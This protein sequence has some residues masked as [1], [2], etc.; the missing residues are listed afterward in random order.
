MNKPTAP[1]N[2]HLTREGQEFLAENDPDILEDTVAVGASRPRRHASPDDV[3]AAIASFQAGDSSL[4]GDLYYN[5]APVFN[6]LVKNVEPG[7]REDAMSLVDEGFTHALTATN[8]ETA[9]NPAGYF[10][11]LLKNYVAAGIQN[12]LS[13]ATIPPRALREYRALK[14]RYHDEANDQG[15]EWV[16]RAYAAIKAGTSGQ[17]RFS[18]DSLLK[19]H[20]LVQAESVRLATHPT[21]TDDDD[22]HDVRMVDLPQEDAYADVDTRDLV[23]HHLLPLLDE[24]ERLAVIVTYGFAD[25]VPDALDRVLVDKGVDLTDGRNLPLPSRIAAEVLG[26]NGYGLDKMGYMTVQRRLKSALAK[27]RAYLEEDSHRENA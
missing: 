19:V 13:A 4:A 18:G 17:D 24:D 10:Y 9:T 7:R 2:L 1:L 12:D 25:L 22:G 11:I 15:Q 27:M 6:D 3:V 5:M 23:R 16:G 14:A 21:A 20:E 26:T 8:L